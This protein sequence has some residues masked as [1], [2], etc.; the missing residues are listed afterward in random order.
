MFGRILTVIGATSVMLSG[1]ASAQ[2]A[3]VDV[4]KVTTE[5]KAT[6]DKVTGCSPSRT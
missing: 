4:A 2:Q 6:V 3:Q 5:V 1:S